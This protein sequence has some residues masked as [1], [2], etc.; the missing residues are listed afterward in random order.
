[1]QIF[2]QIIPEHR[3]LLSKCSQAHLAGLPIATQRAIFN[4]ILL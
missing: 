1:V 3:D 2:P 4:L